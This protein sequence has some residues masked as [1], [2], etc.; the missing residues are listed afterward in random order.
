ME[1]CRNFPAE[2]WNTKR[3]KRNANKSFAASRKFFEHVSLND[4]NIPTMSWG[5]T[6][7][8]SKRTFAIAPSHSLKNR[9]LTLFI[10]YLCLPAL[11]TLLT[12]QSIFI[13]VIATTF[14]FELSVLRRCARIR[15]SLRECNFQSL[16]NKYL[17][18]TSSSFLLAYVVD[19]FVSPTELF[20]SCNRLRW[21]VGLHNCQRSRHI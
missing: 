9:L 6:R 15:L 4:K 8:R 18:T 13:Q 17:L 7:K 16:A 19:D 20:A 10:R 2:Q 12:R 21:A 11:T 5:K 1:E 3:M 14:Q